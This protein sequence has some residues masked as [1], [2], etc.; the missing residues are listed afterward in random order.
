MLKAGYLEDWQY[1]E[2]LSGCPQGGVVSP[3]L[4][5]IYL[6]KLDKFVEQALIPEYTG[7]AAGERTPNTRG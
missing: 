7:E 5:N 4:S 1:H 2:T 3:I 6:D